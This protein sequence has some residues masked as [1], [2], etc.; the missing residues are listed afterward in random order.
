L[1]KKA[2]KVVDATSRVLGRVS[3]RE[4]IGFSGIPFASTTSSPKSF[5]QLRFASAMLVRLDKKAQASCEG[6]A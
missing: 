1:V 2:E 6:F 5:S 3:E 4:E